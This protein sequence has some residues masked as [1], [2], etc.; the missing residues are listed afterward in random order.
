MQIPCR[1]FSGSRTMNMNISTMNMNINTV[2]CE[3]LADGMVV[4]L[5]ELIRITSY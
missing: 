3:A 2:V 5:I 1:I 4:L